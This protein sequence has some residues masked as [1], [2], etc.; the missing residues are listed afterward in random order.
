MDNSAVKHARETNIGDPRFF[1][2]NLR[3]DRRVGEGLADDGVLADGFERGIAGYVEAE[4]GVNIAL[5]GNR[6]I[7][8]LAFNQVAVRDGFVAAGSNAV[9]NGD[10]ILRHV[11]LIGCDIEQGLIDVSSGLADV[12]H[13]VTEEVEGATA[14]RCAI[15]VGGYHRGDG[16]ERHVEFISD[17]LAV[18]GKDSALAEVGFAGTDEDAIVGVNLYEGIGGYLVGGN[19]AHG[20]RFL[21]GAAGAHEAEA[22]QKRA[23]G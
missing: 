10:L 6:E 18:G 3:N 5:D 2:R 23:A 1:G 14:V 7:E 17:D 12:G 22:G 8:L 16:F 9:L 21:L 13:T 15:G 20:G 11:E 4:H 19:A